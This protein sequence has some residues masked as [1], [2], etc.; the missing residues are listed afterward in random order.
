M[1]HSITL[2]LN[3]RATAAFIALRSEGIDP[4]IV[5]EEALVRRAAHLRERAEEAAHVRND[6]L[7]RTGLDEARELPPQIEYMRPPR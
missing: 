1:A 5:V 2:S 7:Q 6:T 3:E 4:E